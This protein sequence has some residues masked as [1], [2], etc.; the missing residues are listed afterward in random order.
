MSVEGVILHR[1]TQEHTLEKALE[2]MKEQK[3]YSRIWEWP[4]VL[5]RGTLQAAKVEFEKRAAIEQIL[6]MV[7]D[8]K[9]DLVVQLLK[10]LTF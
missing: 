1:L 8:D 5:I 9:K 3:H 10:K 4:D 2:I 7:P 6:E